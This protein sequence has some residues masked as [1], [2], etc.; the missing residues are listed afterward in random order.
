MIKEVTLLLKVK[1]K[2]SF[3][4]QET[5]V[6]NVLYINASSEDGVLLQGNIKSVSS[7]GFQSSRTNLI[8]L[9]EQTVVHENSEIEL[10]DKKLDDFSYIITKQNVF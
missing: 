8:S 10:E 4:S 5:K 3:I 7:E 6:T 1:K 9:C 2:G